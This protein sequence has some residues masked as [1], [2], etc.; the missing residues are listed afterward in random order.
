MGHALSL[1]KK[2]SIIQDLFGAWFPSKLCVDVVLYSISVDISDIL[3]KSDAETDLTV[4]AAVSSSMDT[5][6]V[7]KKCIQL[8]YKCYSKQ[9]KSE[10]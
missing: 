10:C 7:N 1:K 6:S 4:K 3:P 9:A 5:P 2:R 8:Y